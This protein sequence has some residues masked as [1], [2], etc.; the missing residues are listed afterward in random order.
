MT[1]SPD[2]VCLLQH[3][4]DTPPGVLAEWLESRRLR[5]RVIRPDRSEQVPR[6]PSA[7]RALAILGSEYSANDS[8]PGWVGD[9]LELAGAAADEGVP[10]LGICFG[11]QVLARALGATIRPAVAPMIGWHE[12]EST[13]SR[14]LE[15]GPWLHFNYEAFSVPERATMLAD[16]P[17][18]PS[19]FALGPHLGVQFHPE[20]TVEIVEE[21][22]R[23][24]AERLARLELDGMA[25]VA[26]A[27]DR[28]R[29][30]RERAFRLFDAWASRW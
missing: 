23:W 16:S 7:W 5:Y 14:S 9:E 21:W 13:D 19:A 18:G 25:L 24:D 28:R 3:A 4:S 26:A 20:A 22:V 17:A 10:V 12:V 30:A 2:H 29:A 1:A 8:E 27:P 15:P 6:D 11:G